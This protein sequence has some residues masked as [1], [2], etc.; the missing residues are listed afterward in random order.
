[1]TKSARMS[2]IVAAL[3]YHNSG[4]LEM[5]FENDDKISFSFGPDEGAEINFG[6]MKVTDT[7][8]ERYLV[9]HSVCEGAFCQQTLFREMLGVYHD[10][11]TTLI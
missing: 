9:G 6:K 4:T 5:M 2:D 3:R 11:S 7:Y 1:M 8:D 10:H